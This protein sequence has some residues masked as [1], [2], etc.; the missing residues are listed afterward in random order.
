MYWVDQ[1]HSQ[2]NAQSVKCT[3]SVKW[4]VSGK[5]TVSQINRVS[6]MYSVRQRYSVSNEMYSV[7]QMYSISQ[8]Y[9]QS[10]VKSQ[11]N[12]QLVKCIVLV[13]L[14]VYFLFCWNHVTIK[15]NE[16]FFRKWSHRSYPSKNNDENVHASQ[17]FFLWI[18]IIFTYCIIS[19]ARPTILLIW[20]LL[21]CLG[22][23]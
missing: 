7:C 17:P 13:P 9:S 5:C 4:T 20:Y 10:N 18:N 6:E 19:P 1:M 16:F 22:D 2:S 8:L 14:R 3:V 21:G 12:V 15:Y 23:L 11:S